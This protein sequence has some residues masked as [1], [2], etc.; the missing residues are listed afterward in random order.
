MIKKIL[1][2]GIFMIA[3]ALLLYAVF[4]LAVI[5]RGILAPLIGFLVVI[6][7]NLNWETAL[8]IA[9]LGILVG[10]ATFL[11]QG[12]YPGYG[13]TAVKELE[14]ISKSVTLIFFLLAA[15]FYLN[16]PFQELPRSVLL[17]AWVLALGI[18]PV[19]HFAL[20]NILSR[21]SW[22][23][24]PVV[25]F[26]D[27]EWAQQVSRS[28]C[29]VR[30]LGWRPQAILPLHEMEKEHPTV[31]TQVMIIAASLDYPIEKYTRILNRHFQK[32]ILVR[33]A[34][35]FGSLWV[36]PRDLDGNLGLEFSYHLLGNTAIWSKRCLDILGSLVIFVIIC[37]L[38]VILGLLIAIESPGPVVFFQERL[39]QNMRRFR[40]LKFRT[41]LNNAEPLLEKFLQENT[42]ARAEYEKYHKLRHDPRVTRVG[43]WLRKYSLDEFPQLWNV[44]RGEMSLVGPRA[45]MPSELEEIGEYAPVILR[46]RP[47]ITGWWQVMGR[48]QTS[49]RQRLQKDEYYISNWSFWMDIYIIMKTVWVVLTASGA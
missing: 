16:K 38:L 15:V 2:S 5:L 36:E 21:F 13:L 26:G 43:K 47:G 11:F 12:F 35:K 33:E 44:L 18:L 20:R 4:F 49:F 17:I 32:V 28:L 25:I 3:D 29:S 19:A 46:V 37:P 1:V 27:D 45:Y 31:Q 22:Y 30:R 10:I 8:P 40:V 14:R 7:V 34:D 24:V 23:G 6:D 9:Q 41:M 39:G 48:H 42:L